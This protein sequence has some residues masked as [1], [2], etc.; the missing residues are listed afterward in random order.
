[1]KL[2]PYLEFSTG[3][4]CSERWFSISEDIYAIPHDAGTTGSMLTTAY[5][6]YRFVLFYSHMAWDIFDVVLD[7][8]VPG[9]LKPF[10]SVGHHR[11]THRP[12]AGM[13]DSIDASDGNL[14][15]VFTGRRSPPTL[16]NVRSFLPT[17]E[18]SDSECW[19]VG[20]V[21]G[22]DRLVWCWL[23]VDRAAGYLLTSE[24]GGIGDVRPSSFIWWFDWVSSGEDIPAHPQE[25]E[26]VV[27]SGVRSAISKVFTRLKWRAMGEGR[28]T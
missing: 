14:L 8:T 15:V 17:L 6:K 27:P 23:Y 4:G 13:R 25:K 10:R 2:S 1:M 7:L 11:I 28:G 24:P 12:G 20:R 9:P 18:E 3:E 19:R 16:V 5:L 26:K 21:E 22:L